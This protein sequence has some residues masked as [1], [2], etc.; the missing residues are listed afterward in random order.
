[1]SMKR[2]ARQLAIIT[3]PA[4]VV[5]GLGVAARVRAERAP[6]REGDRPVDAAG[7]PLSPAGPRSVPV[8]GNARLVFDRVGQ[9]EPLVLLHGLG[10]SRRSWDPVIARLADERDVIA[11]DLPGHGDSPGQP[12]GRGWAPADQALAL[13]QLLDEL[14]LDTVH[15]AGNS[16][17]GWVALELGRLGRARTV[18]ALSPGG[19]WRR[20]APLLVRTTMRQARLNARIIRRLAPRA[21]RTRLAKVLFMAQSTGHP[22]RVPNQLARRSV[23]DLAAASGFRKTLRAAERR[24]FRDG[25]AIHVPVTVAFGSRDRVLPPVVT[26]RRKELPAHTR[27]VTPPGLGHIAM[28]DDPETVAALLLDASRSDEAASAGEAVR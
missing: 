21:P 3:V 17:G 26:R 2:R 25:A 1:M 18:T 16:T 24:S 8:H 4:M 7:G 6:A 15:V 13:I 9:G 22:F 27:W 20:S 12:R 19:L 10:L 5:A 14:G 23:H 28:F 11:V